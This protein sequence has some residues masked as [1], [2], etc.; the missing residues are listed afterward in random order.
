MKKLKLAFLLAF[1]LGIFYTNSAKSQAIIERDV[2]NITLRLGSTIYNLTSGDEFVRI[3]PSNNY[4]RTVTFKVDE[5]NPIMDLPGPWA[6]FLGAGIEVLINDEP[7]R[8]IG[9]AVITK[10]GIVKL[11]YISNG[12]GDV[13]SPEDFSH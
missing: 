1:V 8:L 10:G 12:S 11:R 3:T 7:V 5:L 13:F 6:A 9:I 2:I 4:I